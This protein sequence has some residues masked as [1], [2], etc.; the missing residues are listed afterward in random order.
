M[1]DDVVERLAIKAAKGN[2]GGEWATHYTEQHKEYWRN[3]VRE[4]AS[5]ISKTTET[6]DTLSLSDCN[7]AIT[8]IDPKG[9]AVHVTFY[10]KNPSAADIESLL[11][12]LKTDPEFKGKYDDCKMKVLNKAETKRI[13]DEMGIH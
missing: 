13:K 2:N 11:T 12:E 4:I 1:N 8:M 3:F 10:D 9:E 6:V 7:Y 5:E